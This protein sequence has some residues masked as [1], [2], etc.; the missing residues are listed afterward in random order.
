[1]KPSA[2][3]APSSSQSSRVTTKTAIVLNS[4]APA[5]FQPYLH[6]GHISPIAVAQ[7]VQEADVPEEQKKAFLDQLIT[8]REL[9]VNFVRYTA[10]YDSFESG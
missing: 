2:A 1:V 3:C 4:T 6:F 5:L 8:W 9:S 10:D 7:A